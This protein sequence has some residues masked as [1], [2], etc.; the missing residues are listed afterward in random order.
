[1]HTNSFG[2]SATRS[3]SIIS[4]PEIVFDLIG[5]PRR[6]PDWAPRFASAVNPD[7]SDWVVESGESKFRIRVRVDAELGVIDLLRPADPKRGAYMRVLTNGAGSEL[8]FTLIFPAGT[9]DELI[10]G[11]MSTVEAELRT[12]R[13]LCEAH[14]SRVS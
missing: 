14:T 8:V 4:A 10:A 7:G 2:H 11:Q 3:I 5:D 6:L 9:P 12:V 13:D 1:M